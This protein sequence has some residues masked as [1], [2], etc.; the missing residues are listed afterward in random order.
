VIARGISVNVTLI[1][2]L[3]RYRAVV[4]AY[5][6]GIEKAL[7]AGLD[8]RNIHSV[9][10][11]FVS[12]VDTAVDAE[13]DA[14]GTDEARELRSKAG[15]AN[16]RLAYQDF[17]KL[18]ATE[19]AQALVSQ[20]MTVQRPL[21]ASTGVKDPALPQTLYVTEL[22]VAHTVNT[23]PEKTLQ[24][25]AAEGGVNGDRVTGFYGDAQAVFDGLDRL[26]ISFDAVT[27][28]LEREGVEKFIDSWQDLLGTVDTAL[29]GE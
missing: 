6:A 7:A 19:R 9:A 17:E 24:A 11:F 26:G 8:L 29:K 22:A 5:L 28:Q 3:D 4:E 12:R 20:G 23:M 10:S 25:T 27:D 13:L 15:I 1:F 2:S 21:W 14:I 16:A 18:F